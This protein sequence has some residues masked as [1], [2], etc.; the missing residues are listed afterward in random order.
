MTERR[1]RE[2]TREDAYSPIQTGI[3]VQLRRLGLDVLAAE[4]LQGQQS[5]G[6]VQT[7]ALVLCR[8]QWQR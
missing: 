8:S 3:E 5:C 6:G 7:Q 4:A 2:D 1:A